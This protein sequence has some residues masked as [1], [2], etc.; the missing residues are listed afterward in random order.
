MQEII[1]Y[2]LIKTKKK[3]FQIFFFGL[4]SLSHTQ[5]FG[6]TKWGIM[7]GSSVSYT[8]DKDYAA[9]PKHAFHA[10]ITR[11]LKI[12]NK[13]S[14]EFDLLYSI[15]GNDETDASFTFHYLSFPVFGSYRLFE[16]INLLLG[17]ELSYL[18]K[19]SYYDGTYTTSDIPVKL[20]KFDIG[21]A[22]GASV[23]IKK[24]YALYARYVYGFV[25]IKS[26]IQNFGPGTTV[27]VDPNT[28]HKNRV[29]QAG[30]TI[31]LF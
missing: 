9:Y 29:L 18:L 21:V 10:G 30:L 8:Q 12:K 26:S 7:G 13:F 17:P 4:L 25:G 22:A 2:I 5:I 28:N 27:T 14:A 31:Y 16:K 1:F 19:A 6:Q 23:T 24:R 3:Y 11:L 15:K 20:R